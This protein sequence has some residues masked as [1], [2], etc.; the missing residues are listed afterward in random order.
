MDGEMEGFLQKFSRQH[1]FPSP[2]FSVTLYPRPIFPTP[3]KIGY[4]NLKIPIISSLDSIF[5]YQGI[6]KR[7]RMCVQ[8]LN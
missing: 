3:H 5:N 6:Q 2:V 1:D 8:K 7:K 4:T